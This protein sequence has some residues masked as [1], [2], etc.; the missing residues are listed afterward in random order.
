MHL[1]PKQ[2]TLLFICRP[3]QAW[4]GAAFLMFTRGGCPC[5]SLVQYTPSK[6]LSVEVINLRYELTMW[7]RPIR[8]HTSCNT[9]LQPCDLKL[10]ASVILYAENP[11]SSKVK[12]QC[13]IQMKTRW[14]DCSRKTTCWMLRLRNAV[15]FW[16]KNKVCSERQLKSRKVVEQD[17]C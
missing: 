1:I 4:H 2:K 15:V 16:K 10:S 6:A 11:D 7:R 5:T 13:E 17:C 8:K 12:T 9:S 14:T 3:A